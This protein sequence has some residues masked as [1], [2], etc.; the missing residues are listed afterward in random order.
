MRCCEVVVALLNTQPWVSNGQSTMKRRHYLA[1][2]EGKRICYQWGG[3]PTTCWCTDRSWWYFHVM[4][5]SLKKP[6]VGISLRSALSL[7]MLVPI[8]RWRR[9]KPKGLYGRPR[10]RPKP[11]DG[12]LLQATS[13]MIK[14]LTCGQLMSHR[15][16]LFVVRGIVVAEGQTG[17]DE[18]YE[19]SK[20]QGITL[21]FRTDRDVRPKIE[22]KFK[23]MAGL[24]GIPCR[25]TVVTVSL[26]DGE[27][28]Y[29]ACGW[30]NKVIDYGTNCLLNWADWR[31]AGTKLHI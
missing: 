13:P 1:M 7:A 26:R 21:F 12:A 19:G 28:R 31:N 5:S 8:H 29:R 17:T 18:L 27:Y 6:L 20:G 9:R 10:Y 16:S 23:P 25:V 14:G 3:Y 30:W 4:N 22:K 24:I 11:F 15:Q 2:H